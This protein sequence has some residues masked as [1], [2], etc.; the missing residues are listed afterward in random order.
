MA[1]RKKFLT[2]I[3]IVKWLLPTLIF[4]DYGQDDFIN[5]EKFENFLQIQSHLSSLI[6][7]I[8]KGEDT[9]PFTKNYFQFIEKKR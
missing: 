2:N 1:Q 7:F 5:S 8:F 9:D 3:F 4:Q 6:R